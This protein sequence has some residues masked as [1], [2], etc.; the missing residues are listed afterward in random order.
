MR[1]RIPERRSPLAV[2]EQRMGKLL[3]DRRAAMLDRKS[4]GPPD[5]AVGYCRPPEATRFAAGKSG[6]P[7]G[8]PKGS[9]SVGAILPDI[10][11]LITA[12]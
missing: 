6:N 11:R 9:R 5:Y 1:E 7:K 10:M 2:K 8:R 12:N 4:S 3:V